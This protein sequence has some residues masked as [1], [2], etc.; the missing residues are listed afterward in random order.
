VWLKQL[1]VEVLAAIKWIRH[2]FSHSASA[3]SNGKI[4]AT[5]VVPSQKLSTPRI[6]TLQ[7]RLAANKFSFPTVWLFLTASLLYVP[8]TTH[9]PS[10]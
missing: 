9:V 7:S 6:T 8:D 5:A 10:Q 2:L 1:P 3:F 4:T